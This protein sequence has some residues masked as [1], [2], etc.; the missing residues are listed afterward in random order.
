[1]IFNRFESLVPSRALTAPVADNRDQILEINLA[2]LV[3]IT[4]TALSGVCFRVL[5][6]DIVDHQL[7]ATNSKTLDVAHN[8]H[9]A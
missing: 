6:A 1:M 5:K 4:L 7:L 9:G 3:G 2:I 8:L